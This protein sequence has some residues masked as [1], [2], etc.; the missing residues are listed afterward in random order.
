MPEV[1][2]VPEGANGANGEAFDE[3]TLPAESQRLLQMAKEEVQTKH[4]EMDAGVHSGDEEGGYVRRRG[5]PKGSKTLSAFITNDAERRKYFVKRIKAIRSQVSDT[6]SRC[7]GGNILVVAIQS[8]TGGVHHCGTGPF[9]RFIRDEEVTEI[10]YAYLNGQE[11]PRRIPQTNL[12][13]DPP[14]RTQEE[15]LVMLMFEGMSTANTCKSAQV[16]NTWRKI[17]GTPARWKQLYIRTYGLPAM[18]DVEKAFGNVSIVGN[19]HWFS[20][21]RDHTLMLRAYPDCR[22][23]SKYRDRVPGFDSLLFMLISL[24]CEPTERIDTL[25]WTVV[26]HFSQFGTHDA[27]EIADEIVNNLLSDRT[28]LFNYLPLNEST[29]ERLEQFTSVYHNWHAYDLLLTHL[30]KM[31]PRYRT[32]ALLAR[33]RLVFQEEYIPVAWLAA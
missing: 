23:I 10:M 33:A 18:K 5:R 31:A 24:L 2:P 30:C 8:E 21:Y 25:R 20:L 1:V 7:S 27:W 26:E 22:L 11:P 3:S 28:E 9:E 19:I 6:F 12:L 14:A 4:S 15:V 17:C 13:R 29:F 32:A 16:C